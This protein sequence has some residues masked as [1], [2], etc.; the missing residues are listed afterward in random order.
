[1]A[2]SAPDKRLLCS[3]LQE[4]TKCLSPT[5]ALILNQIA[6]VPGVAAPPGPAFACNVA[7]WTDSQTVS[8]HTH[9]QSLPACM[10]QS[11]PSVLQL[12]L[13]FS[14]GNDPAGFDCPSAAATPDNLGAVEG[15]QV[16]YPLEG[17]LYP[18]C[19]PITS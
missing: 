10:A 13:T 16:L 5:T 9:T 15:L 12:T 18:D 2:T 4:Q 1:M 11:D 19:G 3:F 6:A 17:A 8:A 7:N 14:V